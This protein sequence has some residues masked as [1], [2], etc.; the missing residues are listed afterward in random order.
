MRISQK[1]ELYI[2]A[3]S[4]IL[5]TSFLFFIDEGNYNFSWVTEPFVWLVFLLY[6][7]PIFLGQLLLLKI[8]LKRLNGLNK[9]ILSILMGSVLGITCTIAL[10]FSGLIV[11]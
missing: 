1:T 10:L 4:S 7:I 3:I 8:V 11:L 2:L 9:I 6:A 5:I